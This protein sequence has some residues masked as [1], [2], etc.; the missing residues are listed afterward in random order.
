MFGAGEAWP[1]EGALQRG[2]KERLHKKVN[3]AIRELHF[4]FF[5]LSS[6]NDQCDSNRSKAGVHSV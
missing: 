3:G 4:R 5:R 1:E 6:L 2:W